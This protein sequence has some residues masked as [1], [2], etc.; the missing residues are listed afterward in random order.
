MDTSVQCCTNMPH[1]F[2][3]HNATISTEIIKTVRPPDTSRAKMNGTFGDGSFNLGGIRVLT[4]TSFLSANSIRSTDSLDYDKIDW[5]STN[6]SVPC[7]LKNAI[8]VPLFIGAMQG[9]YFISDSEYFLEIA[10]SA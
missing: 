9:H 2:L 3:N 8:T 7:A 4:L 6:I 10:K 1:K 5:C